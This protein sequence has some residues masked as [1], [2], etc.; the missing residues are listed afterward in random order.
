MS[1]KQWPIT[2]HE[3]HSNHLHLPS[4]LAQKFGSE[5]SLEASTNQKDGVFV[6]LHWGTNGAIAF[7][8]GSISKQTDTIELPH[9]YR[10]AFLLEEDMIVR[11]KYYADID[12]FRLINEEGKFRSL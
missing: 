10:G 6:H 11:I 3:E 7:W 2:F 12:R 1:D 8:N 9:C 5:V 4:S